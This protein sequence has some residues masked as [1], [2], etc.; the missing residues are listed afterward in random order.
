MSAGCTEHGCSAATPLSEAETLPALRTLRRGDGDGPV[1]V[2]LHGMG[3]RPEDM[4]SFAERTDLPE[5]TR[6]VFP[7]APTAT[8]PPEGREGGFLWWSLGEDFADPRRHRYPGMA[9]VRRQVIALLDSL[10][11]EYGVASERIVLGGFSQ[12]A[13]LAM[14][15][16][17][18]DPRPLAGVV[19]MSG[20]FVDEA[21]WMPLM[22]NRRDLRVFQSHGRQDSILLFGP[23]EELSQRLLANGVDARFFAFDGEHEVNGEVSQR[24]AAFV[25]EVSE[26]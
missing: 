5:G 9:V 25:R 17:L 1:V 19:I 6:F 23:A 4:V 3:S 15:V 14:D 8:H 26:E 21:E 13:M 2:M 18:H 24:V 16:V 22:V 12:G 7:Y 10:E 11:D 20:T